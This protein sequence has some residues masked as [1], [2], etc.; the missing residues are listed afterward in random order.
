[1]ATF[2]GQTRNKKQNKASRYQNVFLLQGFKDLSS[3]GLQM[4]P[5][6][7]TW[8]DS[9][10]RFKQ[11]FQVNISEWFLI[12]RSSLMFIKSNKAQQVASQAPNKNKH[13]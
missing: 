11:S 9:K 13:N 8:N 10:V 7:V 2:D 4:F 1:M 6:T 5:M 12:N 3:E